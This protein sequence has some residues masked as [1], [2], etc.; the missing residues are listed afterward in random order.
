V[1]SFQWVLRHQGAKQCW[2]DYRGNSGDDFRDY[3]N[4]LIREA[5]AAE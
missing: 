4:G 1:R 2:N 5:E 3:V